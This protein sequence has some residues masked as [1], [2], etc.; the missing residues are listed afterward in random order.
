MSQCSSDHYCSNKVAKSEHPAMGDTSPEQ[1]Y[2]NQYNCKA[3]GTVHMAMVLREVAVEF[4]YSWTFY[5]I[6][7]V[8]FLVP[9]V[10]SHSQLL[11]RIIMLLYV[12][13]RCGTVVMA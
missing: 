7:L 6:P 8:F 5:L 12:S 4:G 2:G 13:K 9:Q 3:S 11:A 10:C 1:R